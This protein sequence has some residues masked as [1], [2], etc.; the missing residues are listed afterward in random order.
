MRLLVLAFVAVVATG[1][2]A[3]TAP[4]CSDAGGHSVRCGAPEALPIG[5]KPSAETSLS[6]PETSG[7]TPTQLFGVVCLVGGLLSLFALLPDFEDGE[8]GG[9]DRQEGDD[10]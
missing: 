1:S 5:W 6:A 3:F 7:P 4:T 2:A 8:G 9:W 10:S